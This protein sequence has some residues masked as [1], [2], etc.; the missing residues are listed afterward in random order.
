MLDGG[1]IIFG[2]VL[3]QAPKSPKGGLMR[4]HKIS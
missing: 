4:P 3:K 2:L 1:A